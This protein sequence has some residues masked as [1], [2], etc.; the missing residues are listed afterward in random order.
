MENSWKYSPETRDVDLTTWRIYPNTKWAY[1]N[2]RQLLPTASIDRGDHT[3]IL[4]EALRDLSAVEFPW[5][6]GGISVGQAL[7]ETATDGLVVLHQNRIVFERYDNGTTRHTPH[8]A[9]S[10]SKSIVSLL[11]GLLVAE[12]KLDPDRQISDYVPEILGTGFE[13]AKVQHALDMTVAVNFY[14]EYTDPEGDIVM[15]RRASGWD[16]TPVQEQIGNRAYLRGLRTNGYKHG[17]SFFYASAATDLLGWV[18]ERAGGGRP[19]PELLSE[20]LWKPMGA[21]HDGYLIVDRFGVGRAAGGI[22]A[23]TRDLARL[24][25]L[26]TKHPLAPDIP[27]GPWVADI[28]ANADREAWERGT[29]TFLPGG[30][31][32]NKWYLSG[33][34]PDVCLACGVQ[35]QWIYVDRSRDVV[36]A[37]VSSQEVSADKVLDQLTLRL[38]RALVQAAG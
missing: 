3:S 29:F 25:T 4:D 7:T 21:E 23:T 33:D 6:D 30:A 37:K 12:G 1:H 19:L 31:Y 5:G 22:C 15:C 38:F 34:N 17:H 18:L 32:R 28:F 35:G 13:G 2:L 26:M 36:I 8:I 10:V 16:H 11:A 24:G 20:Y 9:F 27:L 14:E